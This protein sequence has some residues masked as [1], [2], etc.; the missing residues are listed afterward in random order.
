LPAPLDRG[1]LTP[2]YD[3]VS[4]RNPATLHN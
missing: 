4:N 1:A 2:G 3:M